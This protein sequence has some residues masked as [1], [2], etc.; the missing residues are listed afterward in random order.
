MIIKIL[1]K[2]FLRKKVITVGVFIFIT[3]SALLMAS[4]SNLF[5]D[6]SNSLDYLFEASNAPHFVQYHTGEFDQ[7]AIDDWSSNNTLI[8]QQQTSEMINIEGS[9]VYLNNNGESE[10]DTVME[11]GFVKQNESFDYLLNLNNEKIEVKNGEIAVPIFYM[12]KNGLKIG[13]QVFIKDK[14]QTLTF[15]VTDFVRDVQMNP[16]FISSKRFVVS[17]NDF[18]NIK[19]GFGEIEYIIG[20]QLYDLN[21]IPSFRNAYSNSGLP[22]KGMA[23]DYALF[24][25]INSLADGLRAAVIILISLLLS[26]IVLLCLRFTILATIEEDYKEIGVMKAIGILPKAIKRIYLSKYVFM[27]LIAT[28]VGFIASI[29]LNQI[30]S[31]NIRLYFGVA[32]KGVIEKIL[33]L[34][35]ACSIFIIVVAFCAII[36]KR[37]NKI[38]VI[39]AI[40]MGN[41]GETYR[42]TKALALYKRRIINPNVFLGIRDVVL[43]FRLYAL[44]FFVFIVCTFI[45]IVPLNFFNTIQSPDLVKYM[46]MG[47]SDI[48]LRLSNQNAERFDQMVDYIKE[49]HD[50]V[51]YAPS[52]TSKY[53]I[54]NSDGYEESISIEIGDFT[55]FPIDYI[56]GVAPILDNE[57]ALSYLN[58]KELDKQVGDLVEVLVDENYRTMIVS[59]IYQD[60]TNGG[61]TAKANIEPNHETALWYTV[62]VEVSSDISEKIDDYENIFPEAK[63]T[64]LEGY[65]NETFG[66]IINQLKFLTILAIVI[67]II[68]SI[69]ITSLFLKML[70]AK[71][72][73]Q[74][75]IMR[76]IGLRLKDIQIQ[77]M[78]R[79]LVILYLGIIVGTSISNTA[80]QS[81]L[82]VVLSKL[83]ASSIEF[84]VNP[85][86]AYIMSPVVLIII[87]TITTLVSIAS[88]KEF[89]I[90]DINAE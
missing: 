10:A 51:K 55:V 4:G 72:L 25:A 7:V 53:E 80:G 18:S 59:G 69:L 32:P 39:E 14:K 36:L 87:V 73:S 16:S 81:M 77:Y 47:R 75:A 90:S 78:T 15:T 85:I 2:D 21:E 37:F 67:A 61:K 30:F 20:F 86:E 82:S 50:I 35:I 48:Y 34:L 52:V 19:E 31:K 6:L 29:F 74:I 62:N 58:A 40:R 41:T 22:Q 43:R 46:G 63:I 12:Q 11:M 23:V 3:L 56:K 13:D 27:A 8:K 28:F 65:F 1:K 17:D 66:N 79:A 38:S 54:I 33:P 71:D 70:I 42:S 76:S 68:V 24:S 57:I 26:L 5:I 49:D 83:G 64:D 89:N 60:I 9:K 45:I 84:V 44:L 88:I